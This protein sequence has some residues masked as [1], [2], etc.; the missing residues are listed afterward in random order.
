MVNNRIHHILWDSTI[1]CQPREAKT[2]KEPQVSIKYTFYPLLYWTLF[3]LICNIL[4]SWPFPLGNT[5]LLVLIALKCWASKGV[6]LNLR[7]NSFKTWLITCKFEHSMGHHGIVSIRW[8]S[9]EHPLRRTEPPHLEM[10][11]VARDMFLPQFRSADSLKPHRDEEVDPELSKG[12]A[13]THC[14][15][16]LKYM[17]ETP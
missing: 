14:K 5:I 7:N 17:V 13:I 8:A 4:D 12:S 10:S 2:S 11:H 1:Q 3:Q 15:L 9:A 16:I 6:L